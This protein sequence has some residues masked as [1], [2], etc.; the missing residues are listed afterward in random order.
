MQQGLLPDA[1]PEFHGYQFAAKSIPARF[2]AGD[3]YDFSV[4]SESTTT[5]IIG[6]V[7]GK[8]VSAALHMARLCSDFRYACEINPS[9]AAILRSLNSRLHDNARS[10]MFASAVCLFVDCERHL[11][12]IANAGH[13][14]ALLRSQDGQVTEIAGPS[15]PPLGVLGDSE[16]QMDTIEI[17]DGQLVLLYT[18]G[19]TEA[20]NARRQEYG[21]KRLRTLIAA[22]DASP[23]SV[24][25]AVDNA[26]A[27]FAGDLAQFD[28]ITL[29]AFSRSPSHQ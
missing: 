22:H 28:D 9:P 27:A 21:L 1:P 19:V 10:G 16:Y 12:Q 24:L 26:V 17:E 15:G 20:R 23:V 3:F 11:V 29:L 7:S 6:D 4:V 13:H 14:S 8:G 2:V 5:M 25:D 18:D